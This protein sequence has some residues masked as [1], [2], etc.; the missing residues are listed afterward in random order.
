M[1]NTEQRNRKILHL[2]ESAI[3]DFCK[4]LECS[5]T[6]NKEALMVEHNGE[7]LLYVYPEFNKN[8]Y[9]INIVC[10]VYSDLPISKTTKLK[11]VYRS[12]EITEYIAEAKSSLWFFDDSRLVMSYASSSRYS[13]FALLKS[14][15][16]LNMY[17]NVQNARVLKDK[18]EALLAEQEQ[19]SVN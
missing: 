5:D 14:S 11:E 9:N 18:L 8:D 10:M 6:S 12:E 3:H 7:D 19:V 16:L 1:P 15:V 4:I 2:I 13:D 17:I